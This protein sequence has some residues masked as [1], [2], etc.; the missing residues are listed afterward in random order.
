MGN[1]LVVAVALCALAFSA[2]SAESTSDG[3]DPTSTTEPTS[4][5]GV[6][7]SGSIE[8]SVAGDAESLEFSWEPIT[9]A[10]SYGVVVLDANEGVVWIWTG[11]GT[12]VEFGTL[13][14]LEEEPAG[15][16]EIVELFGPIEPAVDLGRDLPVPEAGSYVI[17]GFD[18]A[19]EIVSWNRFELPA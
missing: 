7:D 3:G 19:G 15:G 12:T 2:C 6:S 16:T 5:D 9:G 8:A 14:E 13:P 18:T 17:L 10:D 4:S 11:S 1:R